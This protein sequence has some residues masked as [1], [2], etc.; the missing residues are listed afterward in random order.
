MT[1]HRAPVLG[2]YDGSVYV[3]RLDGTL[4]HSFPTGVKTVQCMEVVGGVVLMYV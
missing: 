2:C 1:N 3:Y 4:S